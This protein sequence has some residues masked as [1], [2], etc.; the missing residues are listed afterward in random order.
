MMILFDTLN[1]PLACAVAQSAQTAGLQV[2]DASV[3]GGLENALAQFGPP[4]AVIFAPP[5]SCEARQ[6]ANALAD[7]ALG[8]D[9]AA[10][11]RDQALAFLSDCRA[12]TLAMMPQKSGQV[13]VLGIDDVAARILELSQTPIANQMR[14]SALKSLAKEYG[15]MGVSYNAVICQP[16]RG[17]VDAKVWREKRDALKVYTMRFSPSET[18]DYAAFCLKLVTEKFPLNGGVV[19]LGK[20]VLEMAA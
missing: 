16:S 19:C 4:D 5:H 12:A 10:G 18:E 3:H 11:I 15:R 2:E 20:G 9:F 6:V 1:H 8:P 14:V 7:P 17:L 13:L